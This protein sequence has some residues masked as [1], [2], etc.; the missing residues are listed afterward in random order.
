MADDRERG[1][2]EKVE[3]TR[4]G[5]APPREMP[6]GCWVMEGALKAGRTVRIPSLGIA[7]E[8]DSEPGLFQG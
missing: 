2:D 5:N 3:G 1:G 8:P 6:L 7:I 4:G